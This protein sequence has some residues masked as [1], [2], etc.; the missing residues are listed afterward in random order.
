MDDALPREVH[1]LVAT[2]NRLTP[3]ARNEAIARL[4]AA[5]TSLDPE[6]LPTAT[7]ACSSIDRTGTAVCLCAT[8]TPSRLHLDVVVEATG[9]TLRP[10]WDAIAEDGGV[11]IARDDDTTRVD[12]GGI[13]TRRSLSLEAM[14]EIASARGLMATLPMFARLQ[15]AHG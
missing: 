10:S 13:R 15:E 7:V 6:H 4:E 12:L 14:E 3:Q 11:R 9:E 5:W 2:M 8:M 1:L